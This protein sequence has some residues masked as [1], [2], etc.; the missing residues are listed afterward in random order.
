MRLVSAAGELRPPAAKITFPLA[1][2]TDTSLKPI[3][4][5]LVRRSSLVMRRPPM[6]I[7]LR[8]AAYF[9]IRAP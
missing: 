8:N 4:S 6:L 9:G 2:Q 5:K 7:A 3:A 1:R